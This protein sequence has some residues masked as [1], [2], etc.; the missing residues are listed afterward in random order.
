M[1]QR[2]R[3]SK[4][5]IEISNICNLQC[6][7]CPEV[8]RTKGMI[9]LDLFRRIIGEVASLTEQV[10][11]HLMGDPLV[12]PEL[13][14]LVEICHEQQV[15]IFFVTNG[16]LLREKQAE[17]LLHPAF[18]QVNFSLHSFHDNFG[19][20]DPTQ[21]LERI[22]SW[23]ERALAE[24]PELYINYRLWN[25][26]EPRG[27]GSQNQGMLRRIE[28]RFGVAVDP[29]VDVRRSK[30]RRLK[31]RLSMHFDTEFVWPG[32]ELEVLGIEGRCQGL[33]NHFGILVDGTVVPC[34]LD[35]EGGI[36]LGKI[37]DR[38]ILEILGDGRAQA[39]LKGFRNGKLVEDLCQRCQYIERFQS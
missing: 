18:R 17:I 10:C 30:S 27:T 37:Q 21:Y 26:A 5:N 8:I 35:K 34:C 19:D 31:N 23:T 9:G 4:V 15:R 6:S 38:P 1:I 29:D 25:L 39:I 32:L 36:P 16:V 12:H 14:Q 2:K 28:E 22:F 20:R 33:S 24:R 7:F 3:Y 13:L 11:F